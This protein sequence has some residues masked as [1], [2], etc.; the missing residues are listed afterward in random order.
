M[1]DKSFKIC[2]NCSTPWNTLDDFLSDPKLNL[3]GYQVHFDDLE[4]GLFYFSHATKGCGTTM[5]IPVTDFLSL[6]DNP[7]LAKRDE[8]RCTGSD[9]CVHHGDLSARRPIKC[10][11]SW[12]RD[13][14]KTIRTWP[15][16]AV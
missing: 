1:K 5:A 6:N 13:I 10:E 3:G 4:G 8:Q 16:E 11:C 12:V 9:L 7:L 14:L 15:K 2:P